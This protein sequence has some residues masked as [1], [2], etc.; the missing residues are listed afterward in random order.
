M[1]ALHKKFPLY[2]WQQNKGYPTALHRE[3]IRIHG[4][5]PFHRLSFHAKLPGDE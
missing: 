3:A 2:D 5:S 1:L 4:F